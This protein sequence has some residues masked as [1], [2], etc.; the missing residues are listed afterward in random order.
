M[1]LEGEKR[2]ILE[3]GVGD[4]PFPIEGKRVISNN[5]HYI[6]IDNRVPPS[7][8]LVTAKNKLGQDEK[9]HKGSCDVIGADGRKLPI[10]TD[11]VAEVVFSNVFGYVQIPPKDHK[12]MIREANRVLRDDGMLTVIETYTPWNAP[13]KKVANTMRSLGFTQLQDGQD[14][15][16]QS[17]IDRYA[18]GYN[19]EL[20]SPHSF[21]SHFNNR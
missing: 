18:N 13:L 11:R 10:K 12:D 8:S 5:E 6:G 20:Y 1:I 3:V 17:A 14:V 15:H 9:C 21:T 4:K 16:S 19:A 7:S 2:I